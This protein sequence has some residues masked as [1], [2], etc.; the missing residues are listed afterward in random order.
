MAESRAVLQRLDEVGQD[1]SAVSGEAKRVVVPM[2]RDLQG[3]RDGTR[4][5]AAVMEGIR[6][7]V[8][9]LMRRR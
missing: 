1:A 8:S 4:Q 2:I 9:A 7:G 5:L 3:L 6:V